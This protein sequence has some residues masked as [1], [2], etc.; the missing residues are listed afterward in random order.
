MDSVSLHPN[1]N[2]RN[3]L[4]KFRVVNENIPRKGRMM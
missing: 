2:S 1:K 3:G 4:K